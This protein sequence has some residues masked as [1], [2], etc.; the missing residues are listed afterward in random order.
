MVI[1]IELKDKFVVYEDD[2]FNKVH[3]ILLCNWSLKLSIYNNIN[4]VIDRSKELD[5]PYQ[6]FIYNDNGEFLSELHSI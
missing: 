4:E 3:N 2:K 1:A 6:I 5:K